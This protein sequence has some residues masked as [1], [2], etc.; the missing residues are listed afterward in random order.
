MCT[1][2]G[3]N[4][5]QSG[6][7]QNDIE[8]CEAQFKVS[9]DAFTTD[10]SLLSVQCLTLASLYFMIK[11]DY[12]AMLKYKGHAV[13]LAQRLGLHQAQKRYTFDHLTLQMRRKVFWSLFTIDWYVLKTTYSSNANL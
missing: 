9:L 3:A 13:S 1:L 11:A 12:S 5:L 4:V 10:E 8:A 6:A 2:S 7:G